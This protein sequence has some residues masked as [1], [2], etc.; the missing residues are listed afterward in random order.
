MHIH[1]ASG[2]SI[3][4]PDDDVVFVPRGLYLPGQ[5]IDPETVEFESDYAGNVCCP[6]RQLILDNRVETIARVS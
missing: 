5:P 1:C 2:C 4:I 6:G 3:E